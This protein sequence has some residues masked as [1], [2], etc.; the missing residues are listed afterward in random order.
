MWR[1]GTTFFFSTIDLDVPG[2]TRVSVQAAST[3]DIVF[4]YI[5]LLPNGAGS[6]VR[7]EDG[8]EHAPRAYFGPERLRTMFGL[9]DD[10]GVFWGI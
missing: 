1:L 8:S 10:I 9:H 2:R 3:V 5:L 6:P 7:I 4:L